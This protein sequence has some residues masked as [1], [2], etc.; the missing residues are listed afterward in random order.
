VVIALF[1]SLGQGQKARRGSIEGER[2][3]GYKDIFISE[4]E[5]LQANARQTAILDK[6]T[7]S[8]PRCAS[9]QERVD[10]IG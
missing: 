1:S 7:G 2:R 10:R 6:L 5:A 3:A 4:R 8:Q 9:L